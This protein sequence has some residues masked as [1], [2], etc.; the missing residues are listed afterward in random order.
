MAARTHAHSPRRRRGE[1]ETGALASRNTTRS[2]R[3]TTFTGTVAAA[4]MISDRDRYNGHSCV[5]YRSSTTDG[6]T[7]TRPRRRF[8][9]SSAVARARDDGD[10]VRHGYIIETRPLHRCGVYNYGASA[11][12]TTAGHDWIV[13]TIC[14]ARVSGT[15]LRFIRVLVARAGFEKKGTA[16]GRTTIVSRARKRCEPRTMIGTAAK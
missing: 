15:I 3:G 16:T 5:R 14:T 2:R 4:A 1:N 13:S 11:V 9:L 10:D 8:A 12:K 7:C 6:R